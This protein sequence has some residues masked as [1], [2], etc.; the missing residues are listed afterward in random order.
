MGGPGSGPR[1]GKGTV[2]KKSRLKLFK[3]TKKNPAT[4]QKQF[5]LMHRPSMSVIEKR[6]N[7]A[8][9]TFKNGKTKVK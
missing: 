6:A 9:W 8:G 5:D 1:P 3:P 2:S 7:A 4:T